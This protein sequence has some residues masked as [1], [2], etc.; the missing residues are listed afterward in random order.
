MRGCRRQARA[1][2]LCRVIDMV[3]QR[4][5]YSVQCSRHFFERNDY[6][7]VRLVALAG[8]QMTCFIDHDSTFAL[9]F[10]NGNVGTPIGISAV[11]IMISRENSTYNLILLG[12]ASR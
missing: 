5:G 2:R 8:K 4:P 1:Q 6:V 11:L 3:T 9:P 12:R 7:L 10:D